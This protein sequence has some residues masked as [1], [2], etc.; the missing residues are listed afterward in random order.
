M[1]WAFGLVY[2]KCI[3]PLEEQELEVALIIPQK[4]EVNL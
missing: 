4:C 2:N 1:I 3:R